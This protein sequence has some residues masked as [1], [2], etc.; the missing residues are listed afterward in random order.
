[1]TYLDKNKI[2]HQ[3]REIFQQEKEIERIVLFGSFL[4]ADD[5]RDLD[6]AVFQ[7][8]N[9]NYLTLSLRYRRLLRK[10]VIPI[11]VDLIPIVS[12]RSNDF[13]MSE[14]ETGEVLYERGH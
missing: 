2:K 6:I 13:T 12:G 1:M 4:T 14:I 8:S 7:D 10:L 3:I 9:D 11:P 5:P